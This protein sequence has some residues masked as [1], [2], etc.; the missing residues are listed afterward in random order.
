MKKIYMNSC[1]YFLFLLSNSIFAQEML[2]ISSAGDTS[3]TDP[4]IAC[5]VISSSTSITGYFFFLSESVNGDNDPVIQIVNI[6]NPDNHFINDNWMDEVQS[7]AIGAGV[8][9][10]SVLNLYQTAI[11]R[12]PNLATDS[13]F[14][15]SVRGSIRVCA[16]AY[17]KSNIK[18]KISLQ[19]T[20]VTDNL[21][22]LT[23]SDNIS[24]EQI[25]ETF[26]EFF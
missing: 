14:P 23:R 26:G 18:T 7:L 12:L 6:D 25:K 19:V 10:Q 17:S 4:Q 13:L 2:N 20:N 5:T 3:N 15:V 24:A 22:S 11:G 8:S 21:N 9:E 16:F 1:F